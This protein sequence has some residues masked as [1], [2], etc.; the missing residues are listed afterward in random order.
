MAFVFGFVDIDREVELRGLGVGGSDLVDATFGALNDLCGGRRRIS[1]ELEF[2]HV[3]VPLRFPLTLPVSSFNHKSELS[4]SSDLKWTSW[5][6]KRLLYIHLKR[7]C[8]FRVFSSNHCNIV[9][10]VLVTS[11]HF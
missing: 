4:S 5:I 3:F 6:N 1:V 11:G 8:T 2:Y 7:T 9:L 10:V